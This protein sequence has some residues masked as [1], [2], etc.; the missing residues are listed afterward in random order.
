MT[1]A[2][3]YLNEEEDEIV[4]KYSKKWNVSKLETI[5][6]MI[7]EFKEDEKEVEENGVI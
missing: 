4:N 1:T 7:R 5:K 3:L 6:Y 2:L